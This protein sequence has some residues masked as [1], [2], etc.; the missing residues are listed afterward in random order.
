[1]DLLTRRTMFGNCARGLGTLALTQLMAPL[2]ASASG[3]MPFG[4]AKR[5]IWLTMA[6]GPS[7]LELLDPKPELAKMH[8]KPM[9]PSLTTGQQ[10]AQLQ[11]KPLHCFGP[12]FGF[13]RY[14][15][16]G[17]EIGELLPHIG[18]VVDDICVVR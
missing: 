9:P 4:R 18:S 13:R 7:Q 12:Q 6:G 14:G 15:K 8:G 17:I 11:G 1:M 10:L 3:P 2:A 5:V 16:S